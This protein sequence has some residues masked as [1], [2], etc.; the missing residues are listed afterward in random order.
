MEFPFLILKTLSKKNVEDP[1]KRLSL[2]VRELDKLISRANQLA[3]LSEQVFPKEQ[4]T[5][6][7]P[8]TT[9]HKT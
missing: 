3:R 8:C 9:P 7:D 6:P 1:R 2:A 5:P 4:S